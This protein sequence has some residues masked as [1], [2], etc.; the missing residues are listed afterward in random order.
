MKRGN[1]I[2]SIICIILGIYVMVQA[3]T[4]PELGG[5]E[6]SGPGFFPKLWAVVLIG[7]SI[8]LLGSSFYAKKDKQIDLLSKERIKVYISM[9][10]LIVYIFLINSIGFIVLTPIFLFGLI[11]FFG[12]KG[13]VKIAM[14]SIAVTLAVYGVF[15][16]LLAVPLPAGILG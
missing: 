2:I 7:L 12:M 1:A 10:A 9:A 8:L 15:E 16:I 4:F 13:Y 6:V 14:A 11:W 3:N 5:S